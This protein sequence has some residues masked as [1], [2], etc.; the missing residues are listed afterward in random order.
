MI[1]RNIEVLLLQRFPALAQVAGKRREALLAGSQ[2]RRAPKGAVLFEPGTP[3]AGFPLVLEGSVRVAMHA[4]SGREILLYRVEPGESCILSGGCLLGHSD[5]SANGIAESE[6]TLLLVP[7][8]LFQDLIVH[9]EAFR[10]LVFSAYGARLAEVMELVEA[11]AFQRVDERLARL[12]IHRGPVVS[13]SH[14]VLA[15]ELGS[16]REVISRLLGSFETRGWVKLERER[17]TV[18]DPKS[19][20][21]LAAG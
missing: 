5:Y 20:S 10:A 3:C 19:L 1:T 15:D 13:A 21:A 2:L 12:L 11:V 14:Q 7:P 18:T 9:E 6:V 8:A 16:A 17:V 4:P